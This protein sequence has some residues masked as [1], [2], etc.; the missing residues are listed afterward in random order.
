[1]RD[2]ALWFAAGVVVGVLGAFEAGRRWE[3]WAYAWSYALDW[4][5]AAGYYAGQAAGWII[6][7]TLLVAAAGA[8]IWV[9]L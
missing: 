4:L 6:G 7:V 3:R 8:V 2:R 9:A 1:M 5:Q